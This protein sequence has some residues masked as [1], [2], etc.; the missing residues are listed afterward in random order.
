MSSDIQS[1]NEER[2]ELLCKELEEKRKNEL[3]EREDHWNRHIAG[4][5]DEHNSA[6]KA[7]NDC[8]SDIP[9]VLENSD[10]LKVKTNP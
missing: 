5:I 1:T 8:V 2:L 10:S 7:V 3:S 9:Q 6:L 4:L